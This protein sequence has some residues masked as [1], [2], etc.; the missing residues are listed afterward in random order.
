MRKTPQGYF[1]ADGSYDERDPNPK[2]T[3]AS[4]RKQKQ[5]WFDALPECQKE[6]IRWYSSVDKFAQA[7]HR[8]LLMQSFLIKYLGT[9]SIPKS[10]QQYELVFANFEAFKEHV[11]QYL[12]K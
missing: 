10:D 11:L 12:K 5:E 6:V 4:I 8:M 1:R 2:A 7:H 9:T 3:A